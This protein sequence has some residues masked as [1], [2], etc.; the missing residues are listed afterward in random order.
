MGVCRAGGD[1]LFCAV[2]DLVFMCFFSLSAAALAALVF[3]SPAWLVYLL[4]SA[5]DFFNMFVLGIPRFRSGKWLKNVVEG[6]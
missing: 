5:E 2:F 4:I 3:H 6:L 1:T